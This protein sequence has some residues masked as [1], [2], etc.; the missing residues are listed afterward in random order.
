MGSLSCRDTEWSH[1][2]QVNSV[3]FSPVDQFNLVGTG[4]VWSDED[5]R[6]RGEDG[7]TCADRWLVFDAVCT[8]TQTCAPHIQEGHDKLAGVSSSNQSCCHPMTQPARMT[9]EFGTARGI[10][11]LTFRLVV[12]VASP[13][14]CQPCCHSRLQ[15]QD[16]PNLQPDWLRPQMP[17]R[18][19]SRVPGSPGCPARRGRL[20][21]LAVWMVTQKHTQ[22][23]LLCRPLG[24]ARRLTLTG[25][26]N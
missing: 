11:D 18:A 6:Q 7:R 12:W 13:P 24:A 2:S 21:L 25:S 26:S 17:G 16:S 4:C 5:R 10:H 20:C 3:Q 1:T 15:K 8:R 23:S 19:P 22:S 9:L 14:A